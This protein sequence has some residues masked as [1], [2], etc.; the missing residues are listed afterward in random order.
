MKD[1]QCYELFGRIALKN[2]ASSIFIFNTL[3][4]RAIEDLLSFHFSK[5]FIQHLHEIDVV[6]FKD[7]RLRLIC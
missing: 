6:I 3:D 1:V 4:D 2:H 7:K 5:Y